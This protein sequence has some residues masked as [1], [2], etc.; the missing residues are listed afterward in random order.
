MLAGSRARSSLVSQPSYLRFDIKRMHEK[1]AVWSAS[2]TWLNGDPMRVH[3]IPIPRLGNGWTDLPI[4]SL[5]DE[6]QGWCYAPGCHQ[7][8]PRSTDS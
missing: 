7:A 4:T 8:T 2:R 5:S 6:G 3:S 1:A